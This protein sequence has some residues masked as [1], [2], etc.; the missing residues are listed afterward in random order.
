MKVHRDILYPIA[1]LIWGIPGVMIAIKGVRTYAVLPMPE[2]WWLLVVTLCIAVFFYLIFY[3]I[4]NKYTDRIARFPERVAVWHVFPARGWLLIIFMMGLGI[5]LRNI[6][7]IPIEF[8]APF[9]S[10]LG[11]MLIVASVK[12]IKMGLL[13]NKGCQH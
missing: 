2:M 9:Y 11:P 6:P 3:K 5:L 10:G 4:V 8:T 1:A 7:T 12:F 13:K